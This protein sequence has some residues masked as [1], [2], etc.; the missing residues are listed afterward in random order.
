MFSQACVKNSVHRGG[1]MHV[2]GGMHGR[3]DVHSCG[4]AWQGGMCGGAYVAGGVYSR[5]HVWQGDMHG[6][7]MDYRGCMPGH[8]W[9]GVCMA[10]KIA[11]VADGVH[12]TGMHSR[13][14]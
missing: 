3:G 1:G 12:P 8:A 6:R 2:A 11:T 4:C 7:G 13:L 14:L 5:G 10:G 9:Q